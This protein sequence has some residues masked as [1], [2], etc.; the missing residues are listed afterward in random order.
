MTLSA[1]R[2]LSG[3]RP[4]WLFTRLPIMRFKVPG[5]DV[6]VRLFEKV[7]TVDQQYDIVDVGVEQED[8]SIDSLVCGGSFSYAKSIIKKL[9]DDAASKK[10][11]AAAA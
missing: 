9:D 4:F 11:E 1:Y 7:E 8:G 3:L 5:K 6:Y 10:A 2:R